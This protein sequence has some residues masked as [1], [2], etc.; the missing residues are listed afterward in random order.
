MKI[1]FVCLGNI[2]RS[3]MAEYILKS[4]CKEQNLNWEIASAGTEIYHVGKSADERGIRT[5]MKFG[6]DMKAHRA[7]Q[8]TAKDFD[9][10][11]V[12]YS[13]ATDVTHEMAFIAHNETRMKKVKLFMDELH[14]GKLESVPDPWYGDEKDFV[15]VYQLVERVCDVIVNSFD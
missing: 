8:L 4:K 10:Y 1:L 13:M 12:I 6:T 9:Y 5:A 11:D 7:R 2:C 14:S 3:P 15:P